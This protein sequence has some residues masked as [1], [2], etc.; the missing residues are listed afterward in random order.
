MND[1]LIVFAKIPQPD[2]VKTRLTTLLSPEEA[3]GLYE[4]FL[5]DAL[6][7]YLSLA[8][9][10]R[11]YLGPP[12]DRVPDTLAIDGVSIHEQSGDGLGA[13]MAHAF[14][15]TFMAGY[16]RAVI[17]GTDHPTLP[18]PF[19]EQAFLLLDEPYTISIGPSEDG[20]YYLLGMN[21]FYPQLFQDMSYSHA[22]VLRDTLER[23]AST[24]AE[25]QI[26]PSWYDV[27]TPNE[28]QRLVAD[29]AISEEDL[30]HTRAFVERLRKK[31]PQLSRRPSNH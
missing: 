14:V 31:Y 29:L 23:A 30:P 3:A 2:K 17:I 8:A 11:L 16:E 7:S 15:N 5:L 28:L 6:S 4:A 22:G 27:D 13:R 18:L 19:V 20:G 25:T 1:A 10:V 21:E 26:L 24:S 9:D 12:V